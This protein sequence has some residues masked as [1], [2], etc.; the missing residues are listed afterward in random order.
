MC[1]TPVHLRVSEVEPSK[2]ATHRDL[3]NGHWTAKPIGVGFEPVDPSC[4]FACLK[5]IKLRG[6]FLFGLPLFD[7]AE[8]AGV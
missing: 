1:G 2:H 5:L 3:P 6:A 7:N 4:L 8:H